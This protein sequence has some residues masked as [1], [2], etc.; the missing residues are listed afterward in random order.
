MRFRFCGDAD[1]P[2]WVLVEINTLSKL[3]SVKLKL[4]AQI[5]AQGVINP[6]VDMEKAEKL[7]AESKLDANIDLKACMACLT[8]ILSSTVRYNCDSSALQ[9][10]LQQLG[11]P[12]EHSTSIKRIVDD[13][14]AN[15]SSKFKAASLQINPLEQYS[16]KM[17]EDVNCA[18]LDLVIGGEKKT[19]TLTPFTLNVLIENLKEVRK[20]MVELNDAS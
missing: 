8:Y 18:V 16:V 10:E 14:S 15:L 13:Q 17:D 3:S 20:T 4:L 6:P 1:C 19:A 11:L 2:D 9:S 7:F 12:R 5:V